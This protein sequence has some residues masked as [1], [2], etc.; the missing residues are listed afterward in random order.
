[1]AQLCSPMCK[2]LPYPI[3]VP[4]RGLGAGEGSHSPVGP[5]MSAWDPSAAQL[6]DSVLGLG[7][8]GL[9]AGWPSQPRCCWPPADTPPG[10]LESGATLLPAVAV[11]GRLGPQEALLLALLG[12]GLLLGARSVPPAL[13]GLAFRPHPEIHWPCCFPRSPFPPSWVEQAGGNPFISSLNC[14]GPLAPQHGR[15]IPGSASETA[16]E[17]GVKGQGARAGCGGHL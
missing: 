7:A 4:P 9:T 2:A 1:M 16:R 3:P 11:T 6:R 8:W 15:R 13:P 14:R 17:G 5:C 10:R 12:L